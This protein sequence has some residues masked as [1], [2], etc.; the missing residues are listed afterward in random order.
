[1]TL[2]WSSN[3]SS[4]S[5][6]SLSF[7]ISGTPAASFSANDLAEISNNCSNLEI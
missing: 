1:M 2:F 5:K 6:N 7:S 3:L 4:L